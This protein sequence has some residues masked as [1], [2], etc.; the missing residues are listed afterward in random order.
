ML[1][2]AAV[3]LR[4]AQLSPMHSHVLLLTTRRHDVAGGYYPGWRRLPNSGKAIALQCDVEAIVWCHQ[5]EVNVEVG[6]VVNPGR[7]MA[8]RVPIE[9]DVVERRRSRLG[10]QL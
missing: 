9:S 1:P 8:Q 5:V 7:N 6:H 10:G 3:E 4:P 2:L